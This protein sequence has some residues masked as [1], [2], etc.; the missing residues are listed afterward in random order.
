[1]VIFH[2]LQKRNLGEFFDTHP[3][4]PDYKLLI[5]NQQL[6]ERCLLAPEAHQSFQLLA[7]QSSSLPDQ[8]DN[9]FQ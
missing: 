2:F 8:T 9:R 3:D 7:T 4:F 6:T 1:M 5:K